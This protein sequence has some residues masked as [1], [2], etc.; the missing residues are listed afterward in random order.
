MCFKILN[1]LLQEQEDDVSSNFLKFLTKFYLT[2]WCW[3]FEFFLLTICQLHTVILVF[4][5][6]EI[7]YNGL[8]I[9]N[10]TTWIMF[11]FHFNLRR[12]EQVVSL[13]PLRSCGTS[14]GSIWEISLLEKIAGALLFSLG[15]HAFFQISWHALLYFK[16]LKDI[17]S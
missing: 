4:T 10:L 2:T 11:R 5:Y 14:F 15:R 6:V 8:N 1:S 3:L 16:F 12:P 9:L 13:D 7:L 17:I